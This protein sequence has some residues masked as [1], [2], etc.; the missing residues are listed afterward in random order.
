MLS[1][2]V[3]PRDTCWEENDPVYRVHFWQRRGGSWAS[4]EHEV[5]DAADVEEV[6]RWSRVD[7]RPFVLYVLVTDDSGPGLIRLAGADPG[8]PPESI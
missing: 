5:R 4:D 1:R 6:L 2:P 8:A 3:D 7:G